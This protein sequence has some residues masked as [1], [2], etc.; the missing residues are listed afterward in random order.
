MSV[1]ILGGTARNFSID[2]PPGQMIRPMAVTL[3]RRIF[4][5]HQDLSEYSF[6]D[7]CG[8]SG[9][10]GLEAWSRGAD[11]VYFTEKNQKVYRFLQNNV[12]KI[13]EKYSDDA[14]ERP[15]QTILS[16]CQSYLPKLVDVSKNSD[17]ITFFAPPYPLHDLYRNYL[18]SYLDLNIQGQLW[19]ES[20][21]QKGLKKIE[22]QEILG[23]ESKC[24][25]QGTTFILI[26]R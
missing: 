16:D 15:L 3:K 17:L 2:I 11:E 14:K 25:N 12:K 5:A 9:A 22:L 19:V 8:G 21:E 10:V 7:A 20:D 18:K 1:R 6:Y 13:S 24:Y 26:Y 23:E 4:D